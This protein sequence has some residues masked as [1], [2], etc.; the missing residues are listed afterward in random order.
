MVG[1]DLSPS[2]PAVSM[3]PAVI[4]KL[5]WPHNPYRL[6]QQVLMHAMQTLRP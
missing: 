1:W 5:K 4:R 3:V 6:E 2:N